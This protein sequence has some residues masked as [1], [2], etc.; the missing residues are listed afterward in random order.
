MLRNSVM[1]LTILFGLIAGFSGT[2]VFLEQA[3]GQREQLAEAT[4]AAP[5]RCLIELGPSRCPSLPAFEPAR[6]ARTFLD[7]YQ[8]AALSAERCFKR[9]AEFRNACGANEPV[10]ARFFVGDVIKNQQVMR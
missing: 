4:P 6:A 8:G 10:T 9:A 5:T 7:D 3:P 1:A 2:L